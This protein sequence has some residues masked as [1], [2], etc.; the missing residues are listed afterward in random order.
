MAPPDFRLSAGGIPI[1]PVPLVAAR[2][3]TIH[4]HYYEVLTS[5]K[6]NDPL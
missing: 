2:R 6:R 3:A 1:S 5:E 4:R